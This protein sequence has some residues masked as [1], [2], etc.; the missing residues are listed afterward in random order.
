MKEGDLSKLDLEH[1]I[2]EIET[3][4][5]SDKRAL[6]SYLIVLLQHLLKNTYTLD[7]KGNSK[8]WDSTIYN[9]RK[10]I[11][12]LLKDSP[13]LKKELKLEFN[14]SYSEARE[15]ALIESNNIY[16]NEEVFPKEC[17]WSLDEILNA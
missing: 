14:E 12:K 1:I 16:R 8:S 17:P 4:G 3:L 6:H 11:Q 9:S 2:E 5:K 15:L 10:G 13:S 7:Q